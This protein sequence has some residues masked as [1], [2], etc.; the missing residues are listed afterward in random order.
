VWALGMGLIGLMSLIS[1]IPDATGVFRGNSNGEQVY[2]A[3]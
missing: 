3:A 2:L 1:L